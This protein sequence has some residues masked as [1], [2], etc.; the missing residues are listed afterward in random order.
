MTIWK[1][2]AIVVIYGNTQLWSAKQLIGPNDWV[3][4]ATTGS[5]I[6]SGKRL[7]IGLRRSGQGAAGYVEDNLGDAPGF[8]DLIDPTTPK[9]TI[10]FEIR[11]RILNLITIGVCHYAFGIHDVITAN[12]PTT[13]VGVGFEHSD[14]Y[15]LKTF[16]KDAPA[17]ALPVRVIHQVNTGILASEGHELAIV[18]NG[19]TKTIRWLI[20]GVQVDSYKP[21]VP[22]DQTGGSRITV[23]QK[24][25]Y[26]GFVPA[27]GNMTI[28]KYGGG[29]T[30]PILTLV[31]NF[32]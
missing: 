23:S 10:G 22:L 19:F 8:H 28:Y 11:D 15:V 9:R 21:V 25:R 4:T 7:Y 13:L 18:I 3:R 17:N 29:I 27:G 30:V 1:Q 14:D 20:D 2:P 31:E 32:S 6:N 24:L 26:R 12:D 5:L 16:L